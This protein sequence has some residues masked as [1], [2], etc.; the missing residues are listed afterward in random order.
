MRLGQKIITNVKHYRFSDFRQ[1]ACRRI[2]LQKPGA[3][4]FLK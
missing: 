3:P 1:I 4:Y 2:G